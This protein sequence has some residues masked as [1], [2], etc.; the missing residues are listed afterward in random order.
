MICLF[1]IL[2]TNKK[3]QNEIYNHKPKRRKLYSSSTDGPP[4]H[5]LRNGEASDANV[6]PSLTAYPD[7]SPSGG[8]IQSFSEGVS[9]C[10]HDE[11]LW[12]AFANIGTEMIINRS[13]R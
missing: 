9:V 1:N 6:T 3:L 10:L 8:S 2:F 7:K 11:N 12:R 13:G 5:M 4:V